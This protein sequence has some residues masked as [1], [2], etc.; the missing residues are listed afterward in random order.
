[1]KGNELSLYVCVR[2][3]SQRESKKG[4]KIYHML[5]SSENKFGHIEREREREIDNL[6]IDL[7]TYVFICLHDY[8]LRVRERKEKVLPVYVYVSSS[9]GTK[10]D[11][12]GPFARIR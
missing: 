5:T 9:L 12:C 10:E 6:C 2:V 11:L 4:R 8:V 1:M 7:H 3:I